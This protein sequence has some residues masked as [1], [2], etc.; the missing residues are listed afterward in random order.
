M[1][2]L[3]TFFSILFGVISLLVVLFLVLS[4]YCYFRFETLPLGIQSKLGVIF[5]FKVEKIEKMRWK[6]YP[7]KNNEKQDTIVI[8]FS[9]GAIQLASIPRAEFVKTLKDLPCDQLFLADPDQSWYY[10]DPERNWDGINH[11]QERLGNLLKDYSNIMVVGNC[12]GGTGALLFS[13]LATQA[14]VFNPFINFIND[15]RLKVRYGSSRLPKDIKKK[16][17]NL[18][19]DTISQCRGDVYVHVS[20]LNEDDLDQ[21]KYLDTSLENLHI[22][23]HPWSQKNLPGHL[24]KRDELIP[25]I[26]EAYD[27][28]INRKN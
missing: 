22:I 14:V 11:L 26:Y 10:N 12:L 28:M 20:E 19:N 5:H 6:F 4:L 21:S 3:F 17:T 2:V 8:S 27:K 9:G 1:S 23:Y 13:N 24:K 7:Y 18:L 15:K 25:L 16:H